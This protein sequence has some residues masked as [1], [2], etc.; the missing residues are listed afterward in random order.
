[1]N[2]KDMKPKV[3]ASSGQFITLDEAISKQKNHIDFRVKKL[4]ETDP[5]RSQFFGR[6][7]IEALL[8]KEGCL[9]LKIMFG[10]DD[11]GLPSLVLVGADE[12]LNNLVPDTTGL[13]DDSRSFLSNGP[14]CPNICQ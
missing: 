6:D 9:G 3:S 12:F 10:V 5:M 13:K 8:K 11:H 1:M 2:N 4:N 7:H 14:G